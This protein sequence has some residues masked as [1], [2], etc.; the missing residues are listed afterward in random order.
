MFQYFVKV[1]P[2][3]YSGLDGTVIN[4]NQFSVT[5]HYRQL[6]AKGMTCVGCVGEEHF[7]SRLWLLQR[8]IPYCI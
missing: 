3:I 2:T 8:H 1:V 6:S 5:E 4:T 7:E